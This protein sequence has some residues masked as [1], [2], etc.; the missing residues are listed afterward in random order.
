MFQAFFV[1][2]TETLLNHFR[3]FYVGKLKNNFP[4]CLNRLLYRIW[5]SS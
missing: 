5:Y 1:F 4:G 2:I 3:E